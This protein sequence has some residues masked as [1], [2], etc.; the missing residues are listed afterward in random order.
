[1]AFGNIKKAVNYLK[2]NGLEDTFY[3]SMERIMDRQE[4]KFMPVSGDVLETQRKKIW[5]VPVMFSIVVPAYETKESYLRACID[6]VLAQS[7]K[8]FELII[9]DASRLND[10]K[11]VC[12]SYS[13]HRIKYIRIAENKGI[14]ANTNAGLR[15]A[16]GDYVGLLDHD[17]MLTPDCLYEY[18]SLIEK[19]RLEF[20]GGYAFIYSDEDKCDQ[21]GESFFEPNYKPAFN[22][23]LLLTNNY[24]C[25]F[26]VMKA[27][28]IK[29]LM[30]RSAYDGAQ[31]HDLVLRAYALTT[32]S[33]EPN[34]L[35]YGH[36]SRI[37]YHWRSHSGST[38]S[39]PQSKTYAYEAGRRAVSDYLSQAGVKADVEHTRHNGFYRIEYRDELVYPKE[40]PITL[41][42]DE[43]KSTRRGKMAYHTF[44]NRYDVGALGGP[45]IR[46]GKIAGG[47]MDS[48]KTCI[49]DGLNIHF[50]GYMHRAIL[51]Q[52]ALY[53]DIRNLMVVDDL[54]DIVVRVARDERN[55]HLF[56]RELISKL[57]EQIKK[58][59]I[60]APYVDVTA[61][62]APV[63]YDE[64]D[65]LNAGVD[66]SREVS[67]EGYLNLYD[68]YFM[69]DTDAGPDRKSTRS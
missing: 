43:L 67:L 11:K 9:A 22:L 40:G 12:E 21:A 7:Y 56:N 50:S 33:S 38:A 15:S 53:L 16:I 23:D 52:D 8:N 27:D 49:Y 34:P 2:K 55:L 1:M 28:I 61:Y 58:D 5:P 68:P 47:V 39:N 66:L 20:K 35:L 64:I 45:V 25:H 44:L 59:E 19:S 24:I 14:S 17:D 46:D 6:S 62:L 32:E 51:Q 29:R 30:L 65:Y 57:E 54:A 42:R 60:N 10:V 13:D 36:I 26:L 41:R 48:T 63:T 18:A 3:A 69:D 31:D 4:Y 37:L